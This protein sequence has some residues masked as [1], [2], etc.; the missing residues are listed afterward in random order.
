MITNIAYRHLNIKYKVGIR[1]YFCYNE[2]SVTLVSRLGVMMVYQPVSHHGRLVR[3]VIVRAS[4]NMD[5]RLWVAYPG[6]CGYFL[7]NM[8][9]DMKKCAIT[10]R[11]FAF[12]AHTGLRSGNTG[13]T[14]ECGDCYYNNKHTWVQY[15]KVFKDGTYMYDH[16]VLC[17][18]P[19][20]NAGLAAVALM[21]ANVVPGEGF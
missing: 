14:H 20:T 6:S 21:G 4:S 2:Q 12:T 19:V 7:V 17:N 5:A 15:C 3:A 10:N 1:A 13:Y 8:E 9:S 18:K 11:G 16:E